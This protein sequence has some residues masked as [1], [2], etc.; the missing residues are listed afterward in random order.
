MSGRIDR[1][2]LALVL[3]L[4][5]LAVCAPLASASASTPHGGGS[6]QAFVLTSA[7][8]SLLDLKAHARSIGVIYPTYFNCLPASGRLVGQDQPA[9]DA[10]AHAEHIRVMPRF[11]CQEGATVHAIL[12][13]PQ[14]RARTLARLAALAR[15][16]LYGGL[17][18]DLENDGPADREALTSFVTEV[19]HLLHARH[20]RLAVV[21]DGVAEE[22]AAIS[23]GFYDDRAL[24]AVA[25]TVFVLAWG[26][27]WEGSQPGPIAPLSYVS[28]VARYVAS[29]PNASRFVLGAPMYGL[30]WAGEGGAGDDA[31]AYQ[32]SQA[33]ALA[34]SVGATPMRDPESGE[35][36]FTYTAFGV[37]HHVWYMD[38][39][40]VEDIL[41]IARANHLATGLWRLGR[42]DQALWGSGA[43]AG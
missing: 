25:D 35:L 5:W 12:T 39:R 32:Y 31:T 2:R 17:C 36:T 34:R 29:L 9:L 14:L 6:L 1:R 41:Q 23:T 18:L 42:E 43:V 19:A 21:V 30:D 16:P 33:A 37:L 27:H 22:D 13:D 26:T 24:G 11:N 10:Y 20:K 4:A 38:A 7:P 15:D 8:D 28:A 3:A 40:S